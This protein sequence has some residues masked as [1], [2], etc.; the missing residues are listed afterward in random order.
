MRPV[1]IEKDS[2]LKATIAYSAEHGLENVSAMKIARSIG[3]SDATIFNNFGSMASLF[4]E[5]LYYIDR[6]IDAQLAST[7]LASPEM[8]HVSHALWLSYFNY[9]VNNNCD[10]KFYRQMRH[11]S[12]YSDDVISHELQA[13]AFFASFIEKNTHLIEADQYT[14][15]TYIIETTLNFAIRVADGRFKS[16]S[17]SVDSYYRLV[18]SGLNGIAWAKSTVCTLSPGRTTPCELQKPEWFLAPPL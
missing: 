7:P 8:S 10:A 6:K 3:I 18:F 15:W 4:A 2:I 17:A 5:C 9:L 14:M 16:D 11:S 12:Y 13:Y 1:V